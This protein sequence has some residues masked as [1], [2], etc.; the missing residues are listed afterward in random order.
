MRLRR[1][2]GKTL[3]SAVFLRNALGESLGKIFNEDG[4]GLWDVIRWVFHIMQENLLAMSFS[5]E[6]SISLY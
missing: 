5:L 2:D 4:A 6:L 1:V 3:K